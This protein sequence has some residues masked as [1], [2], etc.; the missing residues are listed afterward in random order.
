MAA[1]GMLALP[2]EDSAAS[3]G[4]TPSMLG[5]AMQA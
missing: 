3:D 4:Q 5:G 1:V 2:L